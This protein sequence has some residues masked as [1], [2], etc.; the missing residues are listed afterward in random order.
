LIFFFFLSFPHNNKLV[1]PKEQKYADS[2]RRLT[3]AVASN[4]DLS[5]DNEMRSRG[6]PKRGYYKSPV[7][8]TKS[9]RDDEFDEEDDGEGYDDE[10]QTTT[11]TTTTATQHLTHL[12]QLQQT[13]QYLQTDSAMMGYQ[14]DQYQ[15][16]QQ[17]QP[18]QILVAP[19]L[20]EKSAKKKRE[21][22]PKA[23][24]VSKRQNN[25]RTAE[26]QM[27]EQLLS[28]LASGTLEDVTVKKKKWKEK[29]KKRKK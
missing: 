12:Q 15:Y 24:P 23:E 29:E 8:P 1:G 28:S 25:K 17:Q 22:K 26:D 3:E 9:K 20:Q 10:Q 27:G 11:T 19:P 6:P 7:R 16:Q 2:I 13:P 14:P 21:T 18:Q 4:P 5:W